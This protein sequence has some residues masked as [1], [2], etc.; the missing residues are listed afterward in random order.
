MGK[1]DEPP[2]LVEFIFWWDRDIIHVQINKLIQDRGKF[3]EFPE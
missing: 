3:N 1:T 2:A